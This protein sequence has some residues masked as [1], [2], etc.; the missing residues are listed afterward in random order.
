MYWLETAHD[1][2]FIKYIIYKLRCDNLIS[3]V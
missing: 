2:L 1:D 3:A